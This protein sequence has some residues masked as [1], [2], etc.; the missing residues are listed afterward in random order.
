MVR[1]DAPLLFWTIGSI[2][3]HYKE[4]IKKKIQIISKGRIFLPNRRGYV[5]HDEWYCT[6]TKWQ[7]FFKD[8]LLKENDNSNKFFNQNHIERLLQEQIEGKKN[9]VAKLKYI[10]SFKIFMKL[11]F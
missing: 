11:F 5:Y 3:L 1:P 4:A 10:A 2:Y 9:N 7:E 6:N 8:L